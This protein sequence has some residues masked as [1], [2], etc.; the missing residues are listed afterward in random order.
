[1]G[2]DGAGDSTTTAALARLETVDAVAAADAR[3]ALEWLVGDG[4]LESLSRYA[5]QQFCWYELPFKWIVEPSVRREIVLA[6]ARFFDLA[7]LARYAELCRSDLTLRVLAAWADDPSVGFE[8][9]KRAGEESGVEPPN[10]PELVWGSG[11]GADEFAAFWSTAM[12]LELAIDAGALVPGAK[13]WRDERAEVARAHLAQPRDELFGASYLQSVWTARLGDWIEGPVGVPSRARAQLLA[14]V[15]NA[16]L[17][18]VDPPR[19]VA[20]SMAP[21]LWLL[22]AVDNDG[23]GLLLTQNG[24][25][26]RAT[27]QAIVAA[28]PAWW[29]AAA[30]DAAPSREHDVPQLVLLHELVRELKLVRRIGRRLQLTRRGR[31][32]RGDPKALWRAVAEQQ[33]TGATFAAAVNELVLAAL[34]VEP[35]TVVAEVVAEAMVVLTESGWHEG[36]SGAP[37]PRE[38]VVRAVD[39]L[40]LRGAT[41][42]WVREKGRQWPRRQLRITEVGRATALAALR[43][44]ALA[45][46]SLG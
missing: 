41:L 8:A 22:D 40:A 12:A 26:P 43:A 13:G 44:R 19:G 5:I 29:P 7:G 11:M 6:L 10:L 31:Q 1:M 15:A 2:P 38:A 24:N 39:E 3:A 30:H 25:V 37:V 4:A 9:Y 20:R 35:L 16:L 34:L 14:P 36:A 45:P 28:F 23:A 27:A 21:L 32:L 17:H 33:A 42:G 18:P 46:R